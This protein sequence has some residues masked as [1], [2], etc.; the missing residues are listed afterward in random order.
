MV[1][2]GEKRQ[3][4][5]AGRHPRRDEEGDDRG[6]ERGGGAMERARLPAAAPEGDE[7]GVVRRRR[8]RRLGRRAAVVDEHAVEVD[9]PVRNAR[10]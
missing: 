2:R 5:V 9:H 4:A 3:D 1:V 7:A 6:D 8:R 10:P